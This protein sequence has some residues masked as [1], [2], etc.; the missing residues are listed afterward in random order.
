MDYK[1]RQ[2]NLT[3]I[4]TLK[5]SHGMSQSKFTINDMD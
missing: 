5:I 1:F 4:I 2:P 3:N